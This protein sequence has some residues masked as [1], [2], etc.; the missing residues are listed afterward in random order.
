M[1]SL[2]VFSPVDVDNLTYKVTG[3]TTTI[4]LTG[5]G[6]LTIGTSGSGSAAQGVNLKHQGGSLYITGEYS[7][8]AYCVTQFKCVGNVITFTPI[9]CG[10][11]EVTSVTVDDPTNVELSGGTYLRGQLICV[12]R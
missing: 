2:E 10:F 1:Y 7:A 9:D 5:E 6:L 3:R 12:I 8:L 11:S 4:D